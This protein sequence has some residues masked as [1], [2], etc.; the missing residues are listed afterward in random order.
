MEF[1]RGDG[2]G[3]STERQRDRWP[4][5]DTTARPDQSGSAWNS[6]VQIRSSFDATG[7]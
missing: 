7:G 6:T 4:A 2:A 5:S 3:L 1:D